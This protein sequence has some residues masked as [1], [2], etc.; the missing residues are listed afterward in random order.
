MTCLR[1][2][3]QCEPLI[4]SGKTAKIHDI[5]ATVKQFRRLSSY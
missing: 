5:F 4:W 2:D 3:K 1:K